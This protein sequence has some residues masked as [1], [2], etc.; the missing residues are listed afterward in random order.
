MSAQ[1][2]S[3][4]R[5]GVDIFA[6]VALGKL[7]LC[8]Y[9]ASSEGHKS[10]NANSRGSRLMSRL[11]VQTMY[12]KRQMVLLAI[13]HAI[14]TLV[15]WQHF[16]YIK[17]LVQEAKVPVGANLYWWKRLTP[18]FEFGA[19]HAILF[20]MALLPLTM[21]RSTVAYVAQTYI[22]KKFIPLHRVVAMHI[23][24][25]YTMVGFV[26]ASTIVFFVFFGQGCADQKS[27]KEPSPGGVQTFCKKMTSEIM[28]TGLTIM[29]CLLLVAVTSF[30]RNRI[31]Y[32][33][34]YV[35]HHL[36]FVMFAL[37]IAH[38]L[39]DAFRKGQVRSQNFKWFTAS[40]LWYFTDRMHA[41]MNGREC[42]V[43]ESKAI[44]AEDPD[45]RK[46]IIL[47]LQR[48]KTF[49]FLPGQY[50]FL[51]IKGIDHHWHPYSIASAP[52]D[53]TIDF[54][55]EVMS[56]SKVDGND[57]WT[58]QL[59][60]LIKTGE[61]P[62]VSVIGPY[63][64]GF[65]DATDQTEIVAVGSGTGIVPMLSLAR[66]HTANLKRLK[67]DM[68]FAA[69]DERDASTRD[70]AENYFTEK[71]S[72]AGL[73][74]GLFTPKPSGRDTHFE[75]SWE[76]A[77][78]FKDVIVR[79]QFQYRLK[80]LREANSNATKKFYAAQF[81][82]NS[83]HEVTDALKIVFPVVELLAL[84][85]LLSITQSRPIATQAM[86]EVPLWTFLFLHANFAWKWI[87]SVMHAGM[88]YADALVVAVGVVSFVFLHEMIVIDKK[89]WSG[90]L[91]W[92]YG[93]IS[94]YRLSRI[95]SDIL[96]RAT[97]EVRACADYLQRTGDTR[98]ACE[99]FTL[100]FVTPAADF[101]KAIWGELDSMFNDLTHHRV[102]QFFDIQVYCT[103][104]DAGETELLRTFVGKTA[105]GKHGALR[106]KRPDFET[107]AMQPMFRRVVRDEVAG[108]GRPS[109]SSSLV[110]FCGGTKLGS[111]IGKAVA[112][113]NA[114]VK[115]FS[116]NHSVSFYQ[117]NY[118]QA[119]P[120]KQRGTVP[121]KTV[122]VH[123]G[124]GGN[125]A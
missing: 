22:G 94:V 95:A 33:Y 97:P 74:G 98:A 120:A 124:D 119:T 34:F 17:F 109:F 102:S 53:D 61:K 82:K 71:K 30:L 91:C 28:I 78:F 92:G 54:F 38:T 66:M 40:L 88:W 51:G 76:Q 113:A 57:A 106:L 26:F 3:Q 21:A 111:Q 105:L 103:S 99:K 90:L 9:L 100:V 24:L 7:T 46:V 31:K 62:I 123:G 37:A 49:V 8:R 10:I 50:V 114:R 84:A 67:V 101:C 52:T 63:G 96:L 12:E 48:P 65:N 89:D 29:G 6:Q 58:S 2:T 77:R 85:F 117:E 16:F 59:W 1:S 122:A 68:Q 108:E 23:H 41:M 86:R 83:R 104:K 43:V 14:A 39:D 44:G 112:H 70:F 32:E 75:D 15:V 125:A 5:A 25:G 45:G 55:M 18:P 73:V 56:G 121:L 13:A 115:A 87:C 93:A 80:K 11:L 107:L 72:I 118:G 36:V 47:R 81:Q 110:A 60:R 64:T 4:R 35:V 79:R 69:I 27:G 116:K 42:R 20:Q 19:M